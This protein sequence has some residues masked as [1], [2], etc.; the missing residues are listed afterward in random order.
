MLT[1]L[2]AA[3]FIVRAPSV[4]SAS[5]TEK[6]EEKKPVRERVLVLLN[7]VGMVGVPIVYILTPWLDLFAL[8]L[9]EFIRWFG[10]VFNITGLVLLA[11]VHRTLGQ[12]WSM[13]LKLG[14]EHSLVTSGPYS[15]VR[16]P[17]YTFFYIMVISTALIS[18]NLFVGVF[19]ITAW[20]LLYIVRVGD[21]ES[22]LLEQFGEEYRKYMDQTGRLLPKLRRSA[23]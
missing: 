22:M 11:W 12:H 10:I 17:M 16:H 1:I 4:R 18:A 20:T 2:I 14:T 9:P 23:S 21:E 19:G 6:T 13:L 3:F 15:R 8:M 5:K 7:F